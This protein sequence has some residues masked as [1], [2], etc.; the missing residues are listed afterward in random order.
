MDSTTLT[1]VAL[2]VPVVAVFTLFTVVVALW[3]IPAPDQRS[4]Q[5]QRWERFLASERRSRRLDRR[6][7]RV[8]SDVFGHE[9]VH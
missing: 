6:N 9:I 2:W 7:R 3:A 4:P 1:A 8:E 5:V